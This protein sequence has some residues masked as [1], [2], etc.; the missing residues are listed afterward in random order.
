MQR[1]RKQQISESNLHVFGVTTEVD[2]ELQHFLVSRTEGEALEVSRGAE[3]EPGPEKWRRL[4][5]LYDLL[6]AG[7]SLDDT[8]QNLSPPK[9][10]NHI[11]D[12]SHALQAWENLE[13][14]HKARTEDQ[15]PKDI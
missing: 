14:R 7:R 8:R 11:D 4:A 3:R 13:P 12:L 10:T 1:K 2:Q 15:L 9:K 6:A 5:A